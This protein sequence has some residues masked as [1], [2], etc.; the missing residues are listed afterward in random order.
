MFYEGLGTTPDNWM[1][2]TMALQ[3][4]YALSRAGFCDRLL[5]RLLEGDGP[6]SLLALR[7]HHA[8]G[9]GYSCTQFIL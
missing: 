4:P 9:D 2:G 1:G 3:E 8:V 6:V 7:V 5:Q